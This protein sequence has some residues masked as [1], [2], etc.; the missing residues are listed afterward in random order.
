MPVGVDTGAEKLPAHRIV[1]LE[2]LDR[3]FHV[4]L[5]AQPPITVA[6]E[7]PF[8]GDLRVVRTRRV[9]ETAVENHRV[10]GFTADGD[11][12]RRCGP[13][14]GALHVVIEVTAR[15]HVEVTPS[16]NRAVREPIGHLE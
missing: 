10:P 5:R 7:E 15:D 11:R 8:A 12:S 9:P 3:N 2:E 16:G 6:V 13:V 4:V 1:V 14:A